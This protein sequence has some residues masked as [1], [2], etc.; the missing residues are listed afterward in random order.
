MRRLAIT[1]N[2]PANLFISPSIFGVALTP[3]KIIPVHPLRRLEWHFDVH[4]VLLEVQLG[5]VGEHDLFKLVTVDVLLV[6]EDVGDSVQA[7]DILGHQ[8][9]RPT[10]RLLHQLLYLRVHQVG[11]GLGVIS[12]SARIAAEKRLPT[13]RFQRNLLINIGG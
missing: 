10:V 5:S 8:V 12:G 7:G 13:P 3:Q 9:L 1:K 4:I 2:K 6:Q 11:G